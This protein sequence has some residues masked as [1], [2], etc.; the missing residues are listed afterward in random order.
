MKVG[1][2]RKAAGPEGGGCLL[3]GALF[4]FHSF[5]REMLS[6]HVAGHWDSAANRTVRSPGSW[7][8][9]VSRVMEKSWCSPPRLPPPS[10]A[11]WSQE[12]CDVENC[13]LPLGDL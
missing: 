6:P 5:V 13:L 11:S 8:A 1:E 4:H 10:Q 9:A 3:Q 2:S 12:P 7:N